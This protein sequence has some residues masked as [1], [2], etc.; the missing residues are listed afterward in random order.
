MVVVVVDDSYL[1]TTFERRNPICGKM[2]MVA[3]VVDDSCLLTTFERR[4][5]ICGKMVMVAAAAM[6]AAKI[7]KLL[8]C[9]GYLL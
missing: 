9:I 3:V 1:L 4:N 2:V 7:N 6:T 8:L 5:P